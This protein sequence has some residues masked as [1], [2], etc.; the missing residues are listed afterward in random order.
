MG[1]AQGDCSF[2]DHFHHPGAAGLEHLEIALKISQPR[3]RA[4]AVGFFI[5]IGIGHRAYKWQSRKRLKSAVLVTGRGDS[6]I[7][8]AR[9]TIWQNEVCLRYVGMTKKCRA[10]LRATHGQA[11]QK[12]DFLQCR[13]V[14]NQWLLI[15]QPPCFIINCRR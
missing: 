11:A 1:R 5:G 4:V 3:L 14:E 8:P 10:R 7:A 2:L 15:A 6:R 13:Q 9:R 12:L